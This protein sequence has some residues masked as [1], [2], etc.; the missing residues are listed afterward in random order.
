[1]TPVRA[2]SLL[3]PLI[4][5]ISSNLGAQP[6][7]PKIADKEKITEMATLGT[8]VELAKSVKDRNIDN[9]AKDLHVSYRT[10]G[11]HS[12]NEFSDFCEYQID[13]SDPAFG[14]IL[15]LVLGH[16][17]ASGK[18][19][20][21]VIWAAPQGSNCLP[22]ATVMSLLGPGQPKFGDMAEPIAGYVAP[23][24]D[25]ED[26]LHKSIPGGIAPASASISY[27]NGCLNQIFLDF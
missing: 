16:D 15:I 12:T 10:L 22:Q 1:L 7:V 13:S 14:Q 23:P 25:T 5:S 3:I 21:R 19:G 6:T 24:L 26:Y 2:F 11:C 17:K 4:F 20:G 18:T 27:R 8:I 9:L